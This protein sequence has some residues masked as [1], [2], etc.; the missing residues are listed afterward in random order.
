MVKFSSLPK[1]IQKQILANYG[2]DL[3]PTP[4]SASPYEDTL[5]RA[6]E[7][8]FPGRAQ[9]QYRPLACR[10]FRIDFAFPD[11]KLAIECD[12]Y[13]SHGFSRS[14]FRSGLVRQNLIVSD[15][16]RFLRYTL[17]DVRDRLECVLDQIQCALDANTGARD[18]LDGRINTSNT[19]SSNDPL[20]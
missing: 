6:L 13:R 1:N 8:R 19:R 14:G 5:G 2:S 17:K 15:G 9:P 18:T 10:K 11:E 12:G 3:F 4:F 20:K 16:W 7:E